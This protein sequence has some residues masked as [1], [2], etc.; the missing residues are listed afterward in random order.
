MKKYI[1][2]L[3]CLGF[4]ATALMSNQSGRAF[5]GRTGSTGAPGD[6]LTVCKS[7]HNGPINVSVSLTLFDNGDSVLMYEPNKNY[8]IKV[9]INHV[10]GEIPKAFGFQ[11]VA[12]QAA[13]GKTGTS[14]NTFAPI[15]SNSK[16]T[17]LNSGRQYAEHKSRSVTN[18]FEV[19]WTAPV[20]GSGPVSFYAGGNGVN[21]DN[22]SAGDG[23]SKISV[24]FNEKITSSTSS[25]QKSNISLFP[26]PANEMVNVQ[27][28]INGVSKLV[29][30]D[31]MGKVIREEIWNP[32]RRTIN[33]EDL[34][35]GIYL[36][37]FILND[38]TTL[39]TIK[40]VKRVPRS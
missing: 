5:S 31:L 30:R 21:A 29:L 19:G 35:D 28:E 40:L 22:S 12:L 3:F 26:N 27:G 25:I 6:D 7:C 33:L 20:K 1:Y 9:R 37:Q 34:R 11:L 10:N 17:T 36:A 16:V 18:I 24:Q 14:I 13:L 32:N 8:T 38:G 39:K 15:S 23:S 2:T 4:L